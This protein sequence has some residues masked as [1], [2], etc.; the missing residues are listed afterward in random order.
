MKPDVI[1]LMAK[2]LTP[3]GVDHRLGIPLDPELIE[4]LEAPGSYLCQ[5][6]R[7][8]LVAFEAKVADYYKA[9]SPK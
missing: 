6:Y 7:E 9:E 8:L 2:T 3:D 1:I 4:S 5:Q